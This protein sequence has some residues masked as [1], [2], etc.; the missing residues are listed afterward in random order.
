M[1]DH[2]AFFFYLFVMAVVTYLIRMLPLVFCRKEIK[3]KYVRSFLYYI[4]Y[5]VLTAMTFPAIFYSTA[6]ILSAAIGTAVA[7]TLA[8]FKKGLLTV[9]VGAT[10]SVF[11]TELIISLI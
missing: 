7:I 2:L 4:P 5:T 3:N 6:Y 10:F 1:N 9:A 8:V 11:L